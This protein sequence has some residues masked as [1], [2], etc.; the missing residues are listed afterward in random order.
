MDIF[1][2][3]LLIIK[4]IDNYLVPLIFAVAFIVF[5]YGVFTYFIAEAGNDE[6]RKEGRK[7]A[8]YGIIGFVIIIAVWGI[9][10]LLISSLGFDTKS[11]PPI[12][13]FGSPASQQGTGNSTTFPNSTGSTGSQTTCT[14]DCSQNADCSP[15]PSN[16]CEQLGGPGYTCAS[17][18]SCVPPTSSQTLLPNGSMC[19][20]NSQCQTN[21]CNKDGSAG[22]CSALDEA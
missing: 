6:K 5:L 18:G 12:P 8:L 13:S 2:F 20:E 19:T 15:K 4:F 16:F 7:Y 10:N 17:S 14:S 3:L 22:V 1:D 9:V 11:R 21:Y